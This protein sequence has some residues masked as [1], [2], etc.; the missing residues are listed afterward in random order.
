MEEVC[1]W[2]K[3]NT[4]PAVAAQNSRTMPK[5]NDCISAISLGAENKDNSAGRG[6]GIVL[7]AADEVDEFLVR[8][9]GKWNVSTF[10]QAPQIHLI[11]HN[12][13]PPSW[14]GSTP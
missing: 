4:Q 5:G 12:P 3:R 11:R 1:D 9:R 6:K 10:A 7:R 13:L 14:V 2:L 8:R